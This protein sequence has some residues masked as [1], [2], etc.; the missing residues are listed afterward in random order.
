MS[1]LSCS[2]MWENNIMI[3]EKQRRAQVLLCSSPLNKQ[4]KRK[5]TLLA[6]VLQQRCIVCF[7]ATSKRKK[8]L[9]AQYK[10]EKKK[11][12]QVYIV[13]VE[14]QLWLNRNILRFSCSVLGK[15][16]IS[17]QMFWLV[18]ASIYEHHSFSGHLLW[19]KNS[20]SII[21]LD[22]SVQIWQDIT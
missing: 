2:Y 20:M 11:H 9:V 14:I 8:S 10:D 5:T 12:S 16:H 1:S 22:C 21:I 19:S 15:A 6:E 3:R 7:M 4:E 17:S 18:C 13:W